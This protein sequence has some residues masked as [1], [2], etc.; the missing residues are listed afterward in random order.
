MSKRQNIFISFLELLKVRHTKEFSNQY[1]N[2]HP[3]KYNLF[4]LSKML[5]EYGIENAA[6]RI[7]NKE[8]DL[9]EIQTPFIAPFGGDFAAVHKIKPDKVSLLWRGSEHELPVAKFIEAWNGIALL[10]EPPPT[11]IEPNYR[12]HRKT[13]LLG[14]LIKALLFSAGGFILLLTYLKSAL[15]TTIG[16]S[17]LLLINLTG[18]FISWLLMLKHLRIRSQYADKICSLFKQS[19]CN[20]VLESSA[21]KLFGII[22]WSEV[23]LGYFATNVLFLL[24]APSLVAYIALINIATLPYAFWSAWYQYA[25]ARQWCPLCLIV[26][27]LLWSIFAVNCIFGYILIP[28]LGIGYR[29]SGSRG[30]ISEA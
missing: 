14:L 3:H 18:I 25:K 10:A 6:I 11:S 16:L 28:G 26:Q 23:G 12:E 22:G 5:S 24:F 21:A 29:G 13:E 4:G 17:L 15:Y 2:E 1:F 20:S 7:T 9:P 27:V 8:Q 19:N 30:R